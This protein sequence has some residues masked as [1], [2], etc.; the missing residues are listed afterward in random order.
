MPRPSWA[1]RPFLIIAVATLVVA[2]A[3]VAVLANRDTGTAPPPKPIAGV[4]SDRAAKIPAADGVALAA[5]VITP[6]GTGPFPLVVMPG[7]WGATATEYRLPGSQFA[8]AG[9]QVV[10]YAQRGFST[11]GGKIDFQ[12]PTTQRDVSTVIDWALRH[13]HADKTKIG[14]L[15]ISYGAGASLLAAAHDPRIK[16][17]VAMS[18]WSNLVGGLAPNGTPNIQSMHVLLDKLFRTGKLVGPVRDLAASLAGP[19]TGT[20]A[21]LDSMT[22]DRSAADEITSL[23]RNK[24]AIMLANAYEDS[25][26]DPSPL[27]S[28]FDGLTTPKRFQL[29]PGDHG[30]PEQAALLGQADQTFADAKL[31]LDHYLRGAANGI[32]RT[33]PIQLV[34]G[35]TGA[36]H[37]YR[38]WPAASTQLT[39]GPPNNRDDLVSA[40]TTGVT[41]ADQWTHT[42]T[43]GTDSGATTGA[44]FVLQPHPYRPPSVNV[45]AVN[46]GRGLD[47]ERRTGDTADHHQRIPQCDARRVVVVTV[48]DAVRVPLRRRPERHG[49]AHDVRARHRSERHRHRHPAADVVDGEGRPPPHADHRHRRP[50][51]RVGRAVREQP[52]TLVLA[53]RAGDAGPA[54][55]LSARAGPILR[56][57]DPRP[58]SSGDRAPDS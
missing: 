4:A 47:L 33:D 21:V 23:N 2:G 6:P 39:L 31:W 42:V 32:D 26:L 18:G 17:V 29:A 5:E 41:A 54:A 36:V 49:D 13:T 58:R 48:D 20:T 12:G 45:A 9:Y 51:I 30:G 14:L 7:S 38:T 57:Q 35:A 3:I 16:A 50:P 28:F 40:G 56:S 37:A 43:T 1:T 34:D 52:H 10:A 11:S 53:G 8:A 46:A 44:S 15:G 19:A 27:V 24:P 25:I 22:P 55:R